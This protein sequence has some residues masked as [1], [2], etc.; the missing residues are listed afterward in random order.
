MASAVEGPAAIDTTIDE[1]ARSA[2][3]ELL[4]DIVRGGLAGLLTGVIVG[5]IGGRLV[6]RLAA[7]IV[8]GAD[9]AFTENGNRIGDI[10]FG[11]SLALIIFAGLF[12]GIVA[13][14]LWV[15]VRAFLPRSAPARA[16]VSVPIA[17]ALGTT[18]LIEPTNRDFDILG[19][20]A[21][22]VASLVILVG[23]FGPALV[24]AE[25]W[26]EPRL[27]HPTERDRGTIGTFAVLASI[28]SLLFVLLVVPAFFGPQLQP[29]GLALL[30]VGGATLVTWAARMRGQ[31]IPT[32]AL[33][34][35]RLGLIAVV[36][37]G[38]SLVIPDLVAVLRA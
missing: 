3:L 36:V 23:L 31:P 37:L 12:F 2:T 18:A 25:R 6:M 27:P 19:H 24:L 17:I 32:W 26:L 4:R 34:L 5:G 9:G 15:T 20:D 1:A 30:V 28:G 14:C 33:T 13:G 10:T 38:A 11:G 16:V 22:V 8:P 7:L 21:L 29:V 35:G